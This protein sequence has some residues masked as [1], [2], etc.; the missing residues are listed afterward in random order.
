MRIIRLDVVSRAGYI[1]NCLEEFE[2]VSDKR[3]GVKDLG[4]RL[5]IL[6]LGTRDSEHSVE[7][8]DESCNRVKILSGLITFDKPDFALSD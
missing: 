2:E 3:R 8:Q 4:I 1:F 7:S 5:G 6:I